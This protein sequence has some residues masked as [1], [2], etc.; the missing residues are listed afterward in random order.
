MKWILL[1]FFFSISCMDKTKKRPGIKKKLSTLVS[2]RKSPTILQ[3][4]EVSILCNQ[5][6]MEQIQDLAGEHFVMVQNQ[7]SIEKKLK[8]IHN[9]LNFLIHEQKKIS[10][11][12]TLM[13]ICFCTW[14]LSSM[15][16]SY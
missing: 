16:S 9:S 4:Q 11:C 5:Q 10:Q 8:I 7:E 14:I 3:H 6:Q 13:F 12:N 2:P 15:I 1:F